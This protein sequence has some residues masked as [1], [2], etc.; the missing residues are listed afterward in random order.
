MEDLTKYTK[1]ELQKIGNDIKA[2]HDAL[3]QELITDT[4]EMEEL[5]KRI[6]EK[7]ELMQEL[8]KNYV[9]IVEKLVE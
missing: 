8:E 3:K 6:N 7:V 2:Q 9:E 4:Y 5:E 1:I